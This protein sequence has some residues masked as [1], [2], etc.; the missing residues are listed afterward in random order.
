[1]SEIITREL[2]FRVPYLAKAIERLD[3]SMGLSDAVL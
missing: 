1:M 2:I 3:Q